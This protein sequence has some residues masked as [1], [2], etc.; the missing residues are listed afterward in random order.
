MNTLTSVAFDTLTGGGWNIHQWWSQ[1]RVWDSAARLCS[2]TALVYVWPWTEPDSSPPLRPSI[3]GPS[4]PPPLDSERE[5]PGWSWAWESGL[6][7]SA[8]LA[9]SLQHRHLEV[10]LWRMRQKG[11]AAAQTREMDFIGT[12]LS[13]GILFKHVLHCEMNHREILDH[14]TNTRGDSDTEVKRH[15]SAL[16]LRRGHWIPFSETAPN[17]S[18][19]EI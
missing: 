11:W 5:Q 16:Q 18:A 8:T 9:S 19:L 6:W 4:F 15:Q 3:G 1:W 17:C 13:F 10:N 7:H 14:Q 12:L 2:C